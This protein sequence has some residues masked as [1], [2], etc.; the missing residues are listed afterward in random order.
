MK[1]KQ[2]MIDRALEDALKDVPPVPLGPPPPPTQAQV[3]IAN[4]QAV[5]NY[6]TG[7]GEHLQAGAVAAAISLLQAPVPLASTA[8]AA[9]EQPKQ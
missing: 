1:K 2:R 3:V 6:L 9:P 7:M 4:L 8:P 5:F